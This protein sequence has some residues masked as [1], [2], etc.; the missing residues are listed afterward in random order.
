MAG[1]MAL[2]THTGSIQDVS[3]HFP[4]PS[5]DTGYYYLPKDG[6]DAVART[7][8]NYEQMEEKQPAYHHHHDVA[9]L[10][11]H[12]PR[13]PHIDSHVKV[14]ASSPR[15]GSNTTT[16]TSPLGHILDQVRRRRRRR[17][18]QTAYSTTTNMNNRASITSNTITNSKNHTTTPI[19][20]LEDD[21]TNAALTRDIAALA[22][23]MKPLGDGEGNIEFKDLESAFRR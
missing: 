8:Y 4:P 1:W 15:H 16:S 18:S 19:N 20:P 23:Y 7:P 22:S 14:P 5:S 9:L 12:H 21:A 13:L 3:D 2:Y 17:R 11:P 6:G 10:M